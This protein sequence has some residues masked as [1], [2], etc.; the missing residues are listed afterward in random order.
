MHAKLKQIESAVHDTWLKSGMQI[1]NYFQGQ[2]QLMMI[3]QN[4]DK[5]FAF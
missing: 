2:D 3:I 1:V 4:F 5:L